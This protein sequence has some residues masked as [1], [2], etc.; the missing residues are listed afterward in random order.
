[1]RP[2]ARQQ[3]RVAARALG[4]GRE[5]RSRRCVS[6]PSSQRTRSPP[7]TREQRAARA[8]GTAPAPAPH[9]GGER[10]RALAHDRARHRAR[11]PG[12]GSAGARTAA[13][14]A[15]R[16]SFAPVLEARRRGVVFRFAVDV[17]RG[18]RRLR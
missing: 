6:M 11:G 18:S 14:R 15:L 10:G 4:P 5:P 16:C 17:E 7:R 3:Q 12:A 13:P 1:M 9:R 8:A 2:C